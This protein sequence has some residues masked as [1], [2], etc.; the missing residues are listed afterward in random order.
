MAIANQGLS[1]ALGQDRPD[2]YLPL[3]LARHDKLIFGLLFA[4]WEL[5]LHGSLLNPRHSI[6]TRRGW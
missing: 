5:F 3:W 4:A 6:T 1:I 2:I